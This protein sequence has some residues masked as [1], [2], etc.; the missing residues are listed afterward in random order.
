MV[1]RDKWDTVEASGLLVIRR[2]HVYNGM[3]PAR[4]FPASSGVGI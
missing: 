3:S 1:N 4:R 2:G